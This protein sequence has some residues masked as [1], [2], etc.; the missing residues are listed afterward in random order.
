MCAPFFLVASVVVAV[1]ALLRRCA[2]S[3]SQNEGASRLDGKLLQ[4]LQVL[5][6]VSGAVQA[7]AIWRQYA[8]LPF[9][10]ILPCSHQVMIS[11]CHSGL[12]S[13]ICICFI[14]SIVVVYKC[15][16]VSIYTYIFTDVFCIYLFIHRDVQTYIYIY[17]YGI[18]PAV[19]KSG[20]APEKGQI[21]ARWQASC[22]SS[23]QRLRVRAAG[24]TG[25][26]MIPREPPKSPIWLNE[27]IY[28][29]HS[30]FRIAV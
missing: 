28:L 27:G 24:E 19:K 17:T 2:Y 13:V 23:G 18:W 29:R 12:V 5:G 21:L 8:Q 14:R 26:P 6:S 10:F 4:A 15:R 9:Q 7:T 20:G 1:S 25:R 22:T 16:H 30:K 3:H 11:G